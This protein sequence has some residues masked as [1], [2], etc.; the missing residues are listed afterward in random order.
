MVQRI[1]A[2]LPDAEQRRMF[3][4][5]AFFAD[6][7]MLVCVRKDESLMVRVGA[8]DYEAALAEPGVGPCDGTGRPMRGWVVVRPASLEGDALAHWVGRASAFVATLPP[9]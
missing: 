3:G 4:G 9:K 5:R 6:G 1:A 8:A 7:N 2:L